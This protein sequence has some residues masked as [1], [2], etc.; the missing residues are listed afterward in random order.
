MPH[1]TDYRYDS[2]EHPPGVTSMPTSG[3]DYYD[4]M[5]MRRKR[6]RTTHKRRS[7]KTHKRREGGRRRKRT[8]KRYR[9]R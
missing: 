3:G 5:E 6:N 9:R 1:Y 7:H 4:T 8:E 2:K